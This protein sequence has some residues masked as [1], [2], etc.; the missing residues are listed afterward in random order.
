[1][2]HSR[3]DAGPN[4]QTPDEAVGRRALLRRAATV[5]AAG[6]GG[7]AAAE[8][9]SAGPAS[10]ATGDPVVAGAANSAAAQTS[11]SSSANVAT[12]SLANS[13]DAANLRLAPVDDSADYTGT[14]ALL[15]GELVNLTE[16]VG[17]ATTDTLYWMAG[18]AAGIS[19]L[20]NLTVVLT[21]ATGTV[22][23]PVPP[24]RLLDT[25]YSTTRHRVQNLSALDSKGR[26]IG[27]HAVEIALDDLVEFAYSIHFNLTA[28]QET[29][30]GYLT[31]YPGGSKPNVSNLNFTKGVTIANS[32]LSP[33]S[34]N[35][36]IFI[37][38]SQ[39]THVILDLQAWTLPDFS[40]LLNAVG[41]DIAPDTAG[42]AQ[43]RARIFP[44]RSPKGTNL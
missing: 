25:R 28:T 7:V 18:P 29:T 17:S 30:G 22:F 21:T 6:I 12:L 39:T 44:G 2:G 11:L 35:T 14:T 10:A 31:V 36:S 3:S 40:F 24:S 26:L 1:M 33:L 13:S 4:E 8:M 34:D 9:L 38:A 15:G 37:Y 41:S 32:G 16:T 42:K 43:A 20:D 27:G 5:A 23:A 19:N